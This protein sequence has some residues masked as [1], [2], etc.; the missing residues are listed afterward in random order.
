MDPNEPVKIKLPQRMRLIK[1]A[2]Q[3]DRY[4]TLPIEASENSG[5]ALNEALGLL[6]ILIALGFSVVSREIHNLFS[7]GIALAIS[8]GFGVAIFRATKSWR[9]IV[10]SGPAIIRISQSGL[11]QS[12]LIAGEL[13]WSEIDAVYPKFAYGRIEAIELKLKSRAFLLNNDYDG[14]MPDPNDEIFITIS[15][16]YYPDQNNLGEAIVAAANHFGG[17]HNAWAGLPPGSY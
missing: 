7:S 5:G 15:L 9:N 2:G 10:L 3:R 13:P 1:T 8:L 6:V 4:A 17:T 14:E 11:A 12:A 16:R